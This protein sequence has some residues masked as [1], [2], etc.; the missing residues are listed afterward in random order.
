MLLHIS[1]SKFLPGMEEPGRDNI[2]RYRVQTKKRTVV[3]PL[4]T[5]MQ[6]L[7]FQKGF[8]IEGQRYLQRDTFGRDAQNRTLRRCALTQ[9]GSD[10]SQPLPFFGNNMAW[11]FK[12][13]VG[14]EKPWPEEDHRNCVLCLK[15]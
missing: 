10:Q 7:L 9:Q 3:L 2:T 5:A 13:E 8:V 15:Q 11:E 1:Q 6:L 4:C 12:E 14:G